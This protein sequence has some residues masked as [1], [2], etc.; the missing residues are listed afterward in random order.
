MNRQDAK[1]SRRGMIEANVAD[2]MILHSMTIHPQ[3]IL[4]VNGLAA[5]RYAPRFTAEIETLLRFFDTVCGV[6]AVGSVSTGLA[7]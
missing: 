7:G 6:D 3:W 2:D 5:A 1:R 4:P